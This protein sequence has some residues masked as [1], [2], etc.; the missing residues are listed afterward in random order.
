MFKKIVGI[1]MVCFLQHLYSAQSPAEKSVSSFSFL[2]ALEKDDVIFFSPSGVVHCKGLD[3]ARVVELKRIAKQIEK[4]G[5][6]ARFILFHKRFNSHRV[7]Y[8]LNYDYDK[9]ITLELSSYLAEGKIVL[10][11]EYLTV[12]EVKDM[13]ENF[14]KFF[15]KGNAEEW[16][17]EQAIPLA[18]RNDEGLVR[19]YNCLREQQKKLRG[20]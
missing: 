16:L 4:V 5:A 7:R 10:P 17:K 9:T 6:V 12:E 1:M 2:Q 18:S 11:F 8:A 13:W 3:P 15:K 20:L 14:R 19:W